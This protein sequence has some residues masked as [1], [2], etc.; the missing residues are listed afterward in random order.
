MFFMMNFFPQRRV[1]EDTD[2]N[3]FSSLNEEIQTL[4]IIQQK[5]DIGEYDE[6]EAEEWR[7]IN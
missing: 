3:L 1:Y 4:D 6:Y 2:V 5:I 7:G